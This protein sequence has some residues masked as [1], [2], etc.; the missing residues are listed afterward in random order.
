[1]NTRYKTVLAVFAGAALGAAA[2][3]ALHAQAKPAGYYIAEITVK[4]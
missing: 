2:V 1:M 3:Q 4:D